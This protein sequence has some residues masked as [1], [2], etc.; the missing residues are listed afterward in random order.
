MP[1]M[2]PE[3][4]R[5]AYK[6]DEQFE[7]VIPV[8]D[9]GLDL[10]EME[11]MYLGESKQAFPNQIYAKNPKIQKEEMK[12]KKL[13]DSQRQEPLSAM[14]DESL[15]GAKLDSADKEPVISLRKLEEFEKRN[16][17]LKK[18]V[19]KAYLEANKAFDK[20]KYAEKKMR[21]GVRPRQELDYLV[22]ERIMGFNNGQIYLK[23]WIVNKGK[24]SM[25]VNKMFKR[26]IEQSH[27][28]D[29]VPQSVLKR[30]S[31]FGP[32]KASLGYGVI[33]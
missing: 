5:M 7:D 24:G 19:E 12:I 3:M 27:R 2:T 31:Q 16:D 8:Q 29:Y 26:V 30:N 32:R 6:L 18:K 4:I 11:Q 9:Y 15:F 17:V 22:V 23:N 14:L 20:Q 28:K 33:H 10:N 25:R 21:Q 13:R 1:E